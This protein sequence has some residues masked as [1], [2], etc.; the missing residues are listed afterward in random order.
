MACVAGLVIISSVFYL[1][2]I[3]EDSSQHM[4]IYTGHPGND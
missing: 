3:K 4:R 2:W 1:W